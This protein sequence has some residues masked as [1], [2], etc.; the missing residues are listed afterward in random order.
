MDAT[1]IIAG[2]KAL[3]SLERGRLSQITDRA[4]LSAAERRQWAVSYKD[5]IKVLDAAIERIGG[6]K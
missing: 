1:N 2:L 6:G 3:R 4:D 5:N